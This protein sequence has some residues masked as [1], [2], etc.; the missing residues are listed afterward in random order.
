MSPKG[1]KGQGLGFFLQLL[2]GSYFFRAP[3]HTCINVQRLPRRPLVHHENGSSP[4]T[5]DHPQ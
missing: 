1:V 3:L 4:N 5:S 2:I